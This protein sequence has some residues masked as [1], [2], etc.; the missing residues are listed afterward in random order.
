MFKL[1]ARLRNDT[2]PVGD[3]PLCSVLLM[4]DA[5]FPWVILVPR[6]AE[7]YD[8]IDLS[9]EDR[10]VFQ[11]ESDQLSQ[12]L[13]KLFSP[14]KLNV[15]ALGNVVAQL[16]VHHIARFTDDC[17]WPHPVWGRQPAQA[18]TQSQADK[19]LAALKAALE[20]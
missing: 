4:N 16:H 11:Q 10:R 7:V 14:H 2:F 17:A 13:R 19:H 12:V 8:L 20:L 6:R 9:D 18:Y 3:L 5:Q 15:A 1:D